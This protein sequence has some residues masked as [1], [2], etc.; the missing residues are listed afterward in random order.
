LEENTS[1]YGL[2]CGLSSGLCDE[3]YSSV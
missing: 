2:C 3:L 1:K